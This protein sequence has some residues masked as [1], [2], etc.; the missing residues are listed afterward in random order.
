MVTT[1]IGLKAKSSDGILKYYCSICYGMYYEVHVHL[2]HFNR[3][4]VQVV[5]TGQ[6]SV[7]SF[8]AKN[9]CRTAR[10]KKH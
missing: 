5:R 10:P 4:C 2:V 9:G 6:P 3:G 8:S 7:P 1:V